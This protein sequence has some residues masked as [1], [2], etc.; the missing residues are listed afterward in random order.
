MISKTVLL[1]LGEIQ[2]FVIVCSIAT[3]ILLKKDK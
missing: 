1:V 2:Q 3:K